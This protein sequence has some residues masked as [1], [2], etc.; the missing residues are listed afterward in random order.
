MGESMGNEKRSRK[1]KINTLQIGL[2]GPIA[3]ENLTICPHK[4]V[5]KF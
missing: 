2:L 5:P 4:H 1:K 3:S